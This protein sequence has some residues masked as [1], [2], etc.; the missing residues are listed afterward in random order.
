MQ[1]QDLGKQS[2]NKIMAD[3]SQ[4]KASLERAF[5]TELTGEQL[6]AL[7]KLSK[8]VRLRARNNGAFNNLFNSLF[9]NAE[10][11]TVTKERKSYKTGQIE[12]YPGLSIVI[13]GQTVEQEEDDE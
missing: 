13:K 6:W 1:E 10:F 5:G 8:F 2:N 11:R 9:P 4:L 3:S 12:K 7:V